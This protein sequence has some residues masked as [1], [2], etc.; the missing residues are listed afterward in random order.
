[1]GAIELYNAAMEKPLAVYEIF[2]EFFGEERI[3]MQDIPTFEEVRAL[4][5]DNDGLANVISNIGF[6]F[7]C[8]F[9]LVHFPHVTV[10]NEHDSST[11]IDDLFAKVPINYFGTLGGR[12]SLNRAK[13]SD[14]S[15]SQSVIVFCS[16]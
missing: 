5:R 4:I 14:G 9:I 6:H 15:L 7:N 12:F 8:P 3:D 2:K 13:T 16:S 11:E 1:M 10:K